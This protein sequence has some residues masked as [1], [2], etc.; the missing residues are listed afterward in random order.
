MIRFFLAGILIV[1]TFQLGMAQRKGWRF[2]AWKGAGWIAAA[3][4]A[5]S[6]GDHYGAF[7]YLESAL[8]FD[9]TKVEVWRKY[10]QQAF[11]LHAFPFAERAFAHSYAL[12]ADREDLFWKAHSVQRQGRY[13]EAIA[14]HDGLLASEG[15]VSDQLR[16]LVL[17]ELSDCR[18]GLQWSARRVDI[19]MEQLDTIKVN[20]PYAEYGVLVSGDSLYF[21]SQRVVDKKDDHIPDR[22]FS[23]MFLSIGTEAGLA[24]DKSFN[25]PGKY[26]AHPAFNRDQSRLYYAVCGFVA[27]DQLR[28]DLVL[29]QK[30]AERGWSEPV[31]L[32]INDT[33]VNNTH[34]AMGSDPVT[35]AEYLFFAS[36]RPGGKGG[37]DIWYALLD[38]QGV[39]AVLQHADLIN[40]SGD[41]VSPFFQEMGNRLYF[42]SDG[43]PG[44]GGFDV[45]YAVFA[46][47]TWSG[48]RHLPA[49]VNTSYEEVFYSRFG[50]DVAFLS[51]NRPGSM[52]LDEAT[53]ACCT[54]IYQ[55]DLS[56]EVELDLVAS[57]LF[58][59]ELLPGATIEV[60]E[61]MPDGTE[62]LAGRMVAGRSNPTALAISLCRQ[63]AI[64]VSLE[65]YEP[66]ERLLDL[67]DF[68]IDGK[69][70]LAL[71]G[72]VE[73]NSEYEYP[74]RIALNIPLMPLT[75]RLQVR[76]FDAGDS[77]IIYGA[78]TTLV[79]EELEPGELPFRAVKTNGRDSFAVFT[80][81]LGRNYSI[82]VEKDG[83]VPGYANF[84]I[85][86][87]DVASLGQDL[88]VDFYLE[89]EGFSDLLPINLYF[90]NNLPRAHPDTL[91]SQ[92]YAA[93]FNNY[94]GEKANYIASFNN[95]PALSDTDK[96]RNIRGYDNFFDREVKQGFDSLQ[97]LV[98][99]LAQFLAKPGNRF[100]I[101]LVGAASPIGSAQYN[102]LLSA[103]RVSSV[104]N[105]LMQANNGV[106]R[107]YVLDGRLAIYKKYT[108]E[109]ESSEAA[110]RISENLRDRR[111]AVYNVVACVERRVTIKAFIKE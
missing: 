43:Y 56:N 33:S 42:S 62:L 4:A 7:R 70:A 72:F 34:P 12:S 10:G 77:T 86:S 71:Q 20:T 21:S 14:I 8:A 38:T 25:V 65:G 57:D 100:E 13:Q 94:L 91:T 55:I 51:S 92:S 52:L 93:L 31:V 40:T 90:D 17:K 97:I 73:A 48:V 103:R 76:V 6:R 15:G 82:S 98:N 3:D 61:L 75:A 87:A 32:E 39:P 30:T 19:P 110:R 74:D 67:F 109:E 24:L 22:Y 53:E 54:D 63:Y 104:Y 1:A 23:R 11:E 47:N 64:R 26:I 37:L 88:V 27:D 49:P 28:C 78:I 96:D 59:K 102:L 45:Y 101:E 69:Y 18:Y 84:V 2:N 58:T 106:L 108:G 83:F 66:A 29:R 105:Y 99:K 41:E 50:C 107:Q 111:N 46:E 36:D 35:G 95:D 79:R 60:Y 80:I 85:S 44:L 5:A 81:Q 68:S 16:E 89:R 9:S